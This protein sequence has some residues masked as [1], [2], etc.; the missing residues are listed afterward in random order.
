MTDDDRFRQIAEDP[1]GAGAKAADTKAETPPP[2]AFVKVQMLAR[3]GEP[4][5]EPEFRRLI[6][7]E[8]PITVARPRFIVV[9]E[10]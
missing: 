5:S 6:I 3:D 2:P 8:D 9:E 4:A 10:D 1:T 7:K